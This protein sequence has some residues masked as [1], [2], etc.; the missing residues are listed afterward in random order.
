LYFFIFEIILVLTVAV[1]YNIILLN[2]L[3]KY[4]GLFFKLTFMFVKL[5]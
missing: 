1:I 5:F 4:K 2:L 3:I